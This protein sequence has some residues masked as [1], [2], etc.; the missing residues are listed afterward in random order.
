M[1]IKQYLPKEILYRFILFYDIPD[2]QLNYCIAAYCGDKDDNA[3]LA[4]CYLDSMCGISYRVI[5]CAKLSDDGDIAFNRC[6][7]GQIKMMMTYREGVLDGEAHI[8]QDGE[9]SEF[10]E[11]EERIKQGYG[12]YEELVSVNDEIPFDMFRH[13]SYPTDIFTIML[14]PNK[15]GERMWLR[16]VSRNE[17]GSVIAKLIDEPFNPEMG[18]HVGDIVTVIPYD[19]GTGEMK[20]LAI[21]P[22]MED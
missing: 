1:N 16:E 17:D 3:V 11:H 2:E 8:F 5:C 20:P 4:Y 22:W 21:L 14:G 9:L 10:S 13:P 19:V 6:E 15:S 12:Y 18:V 7:L